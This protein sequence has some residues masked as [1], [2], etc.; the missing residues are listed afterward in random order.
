[1][2]TVTS[3]IFAITGGASGI[4][5]ATCRL[6]AERGA[7]VICVGD[8]SDKDFDELEKSIREINPS[9][10]VSCKYLDV[11]S[12]AK[13]EEWMQGIIA[14]HRDLHGAANIAGMAQG[15]GLRQSPTILEE[16]DADWSKIMKVNLDGV[17]YCTRAEVRAMKDLPFCD[18]SVVNVSSIAA[19]AHMP[20]VYAYGTSKAACAYFTDCV[21][22]DTFPMGIRVNSVSPGVTNTPLLPHFMPNARSLDEVEER[23]KKEGYGMIQPEDVA[24]TI[25]WLLSEDSRPVHGAS[26]NVG[27]CTLLITEATAISAQAKSFDNVPGIWAEDQIQAWKR[28]SDSVHAKGSYIWLQLWSVG[29]AAEVDVVRANGFDVASS[30]AVPMGPDDPTPRALTEAEIEQYIEEHVK[31]AKNATDAGFDGVEIHGASGYLIDQFLQ[32]SCNKRTDEWGGSIEKRARF[33]LEVTRR[34]VDAIGAE[35]VGIKL[36]PWSTF[37]GM[38]KMEDLVPQFEY[39]IS[40]LKGL[41]IAYLHLANSRW[42]E[43][44]THPDIHNKAFV[45]IWGTSKPIMLAGGYDAESAR[46]GVD[47]VYASQNNVAVVIGRLFISNPDLPFRLKHGVSLSKYDRDTFYTP[48]NPEKGYVDYPFCNEFSILA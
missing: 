42:I 34:I 5:A 17:F 39:F 32:S 48:V 43:D 45:G 23:Y 1:M 20:D 29:R 27:A 9:T 21:A 47:K 18:R 15:A 38:G 22:S 6:L 13:V 14:T 35:R 36:S 12:S 19:F 2:A 44:E 33:G 30:S 10:Q 25:V 31:A 26:I 40:E 46:E 28:V 11:T 37:Q 41:D 16:S 4:G 7:A 24:R 8:V 3:R